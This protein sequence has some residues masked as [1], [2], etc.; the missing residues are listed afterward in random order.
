MAA[1]VQRFFNDLAGSTTFW[2]VGG[3]AALIAVIALV[4]GGR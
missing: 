3:V 1:E 2:V 4:R